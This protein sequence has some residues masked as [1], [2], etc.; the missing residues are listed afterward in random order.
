TFLT[1]A[2]L[3]VIVFVFVTLTMRGQVRQS[4]AANLESSQRMFAA[5]E[6]RRQREMQM[7][8]SALA[9]NP[10]LKAALDTYQTESRRSSDESVRGYLLTTIDNELKKVAAVAESDAL[11]LV[12]A[13]QNTMAAAGRFADRWPRGQP[14]AFAATNEGHAFDGIARATPGVFRVVAVPLRLD[15]GSTIGT[16]YAATSLDQGYAEELA[17]L[18]GTRVAIV[19]DG[20]VLASTLSP[21]AAREFESTVASARPVE[22]TTSLDGE[23]HAFRRLVA[24]GDTGFYALGSID[25]LSRSAQ[26]AAMRTMA[27]IAVGATA[28]ALIRSF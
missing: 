27:F 22:G 10:T 9:E 24:I 8:A 2:L 25:Q 13:R 28:L 4:V 23:S 18:A 15:D 12:D 16:F 26:T 1:V 20:R 5:L 11:V 17:R 14:V 3:L 21:Q 7:Q 6:T 19:N